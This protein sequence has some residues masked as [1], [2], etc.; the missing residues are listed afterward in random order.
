MLDG[1]FHFN[2][3]PSE[4][5]LN[6]LSTI[7]FTDSEDEIDDQLDINDKNEK[8]DLFFFFSRHNLDFF[9]LFL[10]EC[11]NISRF[12]EGDF[13]SF[14]LACVTYLCF[15]VEEITKISD[16]LFAGSSYELSPA[17]SFFALPQNW[18]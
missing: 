5:V 16:T 17:L 1:R 10:L 7:W 18:S 8:G 6:L 11:F 3:A 14:F 2:S 15:F 9:R 4:A 12:D 13:F